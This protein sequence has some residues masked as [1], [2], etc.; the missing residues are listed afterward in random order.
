MW[1]YVCVYLFIP[2]VVYK[3]KQSWPRDAFASCTRL[4]SQ[5]WTKYTYTAKGL[6]ERVS[7][8][9]YRHNPH[10]GRHTER[11]REG[12]G[13]AR[14]RP[15][16]SNSR[17]QAHTDASISFA[18]AGCCCTPLWPLFLRSPTPPLSFS[19]LT[20]ELWRK[21]FCKPFSHLSL[22]SLNFSYLRGGEKIENHLVP[23][24]PQVQRKCPRWKG[25]R[26]GG[27]SKLLLPGVRSC[28]I[29]PRREFVIARRCHDRRG[30]GGGRG[31]EIYSRGT[32]RRLKICCN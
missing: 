13:G 29:S 2:C 15:V 32:R 3:R 28:L 24:L 21:P 23:S 7:P 30:G 25:E 18:A 8:C 10:R 26:R 22:R 6:T 12:C 20:T 5:A 27:F 4:F 17:T 9:R 1:V 19:I 31:N 14:V 16:T 11:E